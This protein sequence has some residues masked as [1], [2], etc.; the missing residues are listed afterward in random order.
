MTSDWLQRPRFI[1]M[2]SLATLLVLLVA[3]GSAAPEPASEPAA[4]PE[5]AAKTEPAA[6]ADSQSGGH[7]VGNP[8]CR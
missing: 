4:A 3:C 7:P 8:S 5:P 2:I 1:A 6:P